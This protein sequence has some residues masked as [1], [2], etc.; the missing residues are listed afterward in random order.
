MAINLESHL[1]RIHIIQHNYRRAVIIQDQ[2]PEVFHCVWQRMLG[3]YKS[4]GLFIALQTQTRKIQIYPGKC[5][6][7]KLSYF[8]HMGVCD[9]KH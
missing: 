8:V 5:N 7:R 6:R 3:D 4:R 9:I 2:P 1:G